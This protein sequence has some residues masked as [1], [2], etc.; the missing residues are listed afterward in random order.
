MIVGSNKQS[1][2]LSFTKGENILLYK[3]ST[4]DQL[5]TLDPGTGAEHALDPRLDSW[6]FRRLGDA[7]RYLAHGRDG[8]VVGDLESGSQAPL[9]ALTGGHQVPTLLADGSGLLMLQGDERE[10]ALS[11]ARYRIDGGRVE[12]IRD[13]LI[14][15]PI[16]AS[17]DRMVV[18]I[19]SGDLPRFAIIDGNGEELGSFSIPRGSKII[20]IQI[21]AQHVAYVVGT[22]DLSILRLRTFGSRR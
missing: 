12:L 17:Q 16:A 7:G 6:A 8:W 11:L 20:D 21:A 5:R 4:D 2:D 19:T 1:R 13:D 10:T 22:E 9:P 3:L 18:P 15:G 14:G